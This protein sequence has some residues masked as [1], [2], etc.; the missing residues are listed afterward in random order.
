M[1]SKLNKRKKVSYVVSD[2][3]TFTNDLYSDSCL[4]DNTAGERYSSQTLKKLGAG[5]EGETTSH[6]AAR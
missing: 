3:R 1:C 5:C 4:H 2:Y 6:H